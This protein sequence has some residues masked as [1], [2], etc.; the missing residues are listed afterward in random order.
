MIG[1]PD[2]GETPRVIQGP[3]MVFCKDHN[4]LMY[5][6]SIMTPHPAAESESESSSSE[7]DDL[8]D[9]KELTLRTSLAGL[10][11]KGF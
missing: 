11:K 10:K 3:K 1:D 9:V 6:A 8:S 7:E 2:I 5:P 4:L